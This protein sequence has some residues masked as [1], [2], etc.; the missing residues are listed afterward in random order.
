MPS[1]Y[2]LE[3][4]NIKQGSLHFHFPLGCTNYVANLDGMNV[5]GEFGTLDRELLQTN[6]TH[7]GSSG[8]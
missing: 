8:T 5:V 6:N 1:C 7:M 4:L 3:I 2:H